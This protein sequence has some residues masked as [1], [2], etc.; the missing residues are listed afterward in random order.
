M[1]IDNQAVTRLGRNHMA[2]NSTIKLISPRQ[3]RDLTN[4]HFDDPRLHEGITC[5]S[6][7]MLYYETNL[8]L[9]TEASI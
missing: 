1:K 4:V 3:S 9:T 7:N 5:R 6:R 2:T 8:W